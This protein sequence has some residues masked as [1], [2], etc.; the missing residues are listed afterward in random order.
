M[1]QKHAN[2]DELLMIF[3]IFFCRPQNIY[4]YYTKCTM[5]Y[6]PINMTFSFEVGMRTQK[7]IG[8]KVLFKELLSTPLQHY[9]MRIGNSIQ[10]T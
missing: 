1:L 7:Q 3:Q 9:G 4:V 2:L 10:V 5:Y 8:N 6:R